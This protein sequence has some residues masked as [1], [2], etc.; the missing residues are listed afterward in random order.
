[1]YNSNGTVTT[2]T[3]APDY[4]TTLGFDGLAP[5]GDSMYRIQIT[6]RVLSTYA[7]RGEMDL[8]YVPGTNKTPGGYTADNKASVPGSIAMLKRPRPVSTDTI[9]AGIVGR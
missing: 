1:T 8:F 3:G 5:N 6:Y 7:G 9:L 2:L 4:V